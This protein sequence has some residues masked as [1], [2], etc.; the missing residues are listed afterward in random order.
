MKTR[1]NP[2]VAA[3]ILGAVLLVVLIL[4]YRANFIPEAPTWKPPK[5]QEFGGAPPV[6]APPGTS[7]APAS[8][9]SRNVAPAPPT[10]G[11]P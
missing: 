5:G 1:I 2:F 4:G 8:T 10:G 3:S 9:R 7:G 11:A 6:V